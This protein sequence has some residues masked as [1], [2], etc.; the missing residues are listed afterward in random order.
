MTHT[1]YFTQEAFLM[2][3]MVVGFKRAK[4]RVGG[5]KR[6]VVEGEFI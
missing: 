4:V 5:G 1:R 3:A 2:R 6:G